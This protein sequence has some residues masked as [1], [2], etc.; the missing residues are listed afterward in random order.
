LKNDEYKSFFNAMRRIYSEEGGLAFYRGY[1][2]YMLAVRY[3]FS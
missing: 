2:A 3:K 1:M